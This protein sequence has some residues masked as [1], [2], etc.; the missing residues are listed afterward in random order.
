MPAGPNDTTVSWGTMDANGAVWM[1]QMVAMVK[2]LKN[3]G[4]PG[5]QDILDKY[6]FQTADFGTP[7]T[8]IK[9]AARTGW[10]G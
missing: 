10:I 7:G 9:N 3:L 6:G 2:E 4:R 1:T 5:V 8:K